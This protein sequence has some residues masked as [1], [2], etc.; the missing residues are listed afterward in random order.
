MRLLAAVGV[1]LFVASPAFASPVVSADEAEAM[2][3]EALGDRAP[4]KIIGDAPYVLEEP[5]APVDLTN[6]RNSAE[7]QECETVPVRTAPLEDG[8]KVIKR[9]NRCN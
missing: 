2:R 9:I 8:T 4:A 3:V 1:A 6:G 5:I 7:P